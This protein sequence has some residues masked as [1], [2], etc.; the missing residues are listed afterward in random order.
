MIGREV[1]AAIP[2]TLFLL[3]SVTLYG[4]YDDEWLIE[5]TMP[6]IRELATQLS[7]GTNG[8]VIKILR[9]IYTYITYNYTYQQSAIPKSCDETLSGGYGDCDDLAILF[10]S[11]NRFKARKRRDHQKLSFQ[12]ASVDMNSLSK[13]DWNR[14]VVGQC[15]SY[16]QCLPFAQEGTFFKKEYL[17]SESC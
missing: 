1:N 9:N 16:F 12:A 10:T 14:H 7:N 17:R 15:M 2:V 8:N 3:I 13:K 4:F 5:P 11:M 6:E